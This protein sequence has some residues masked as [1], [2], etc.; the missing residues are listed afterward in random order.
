MDSE[1]RSIAN[2]IRQQQP[3]DAR[4]A[5]GR[6]LKAHP[7]SAEAWYMLSVVET[8]ADKRLRAAQKAA[9]L[10]PSS[11]KYGKRLA[12]LIASPR[13]SSRAGRRWWL[14]PLVL[15]LVAGV[16]LWAVL[17]TRQPADMLPT[18]A[19]F[20]LGET[21]TH[22][23]TNAPVP[24][25]TVTARG[26]AQPSPTP[27]AIVLTITPTNVR[28]SATLSSLDIMQ[29]AT[30]LDP[31]WPT[32]M[33]V[34]PVASATITPTSIPP[35]A[36][37]PAATATVPVIATVNADD[38]IP[39]NQVADIGIGQLLVIDA[40]R[41]AG[42]A[43]QE[44]GGSVPPAPADQEW[45]LVELLLICAGEANCTPDTGVFSLTGS[46]G[47]SY[48]LAAAFQLE[49]VFNSQ[50]FTAG[51]TWGYLGFVVPSSES[52]LWLT[53]GQGSTVYRFALQ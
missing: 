36:T 17:Q 9:A 50:G 31:L 15:F 22:T 35:T 46:S 48:P 13:L 14:L 29:T 45:V 4:R 33:V 52:S 28:P 41:Q 23:P 1:L 42:P 6:Y 38:A 7:D 40:V 11:E 5:L 47:R 49:P 20:T 30:A 39:L 53:L 37:L 19:A 21:Q 10:D 2:L 43:I 34:N 32:S 8:D 25:A 44:R 51:Q 24:T 12:R 27:E 16:I 3:A 26:S 18:Q